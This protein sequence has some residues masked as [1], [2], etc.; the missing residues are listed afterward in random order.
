MTLH[1]VPSPFVAAGHHGDKPMP[2]NAFAEQAIL[3]AVLLDN[4]HYHEAAGRIDAADFSLDAHR[5][6]FL[7]IGELLQAGSSV[8]MITLVEQLQRNKEL[9]LIGGAAYL[10]SLTEGLPR[11]P[12]IEDYVRIVKDKSLLRQTI[13]ESDRLGVLAVDQAGS[14]EEVL[15]EAELAFRRI[16]GQAISPGLISVAGYLQRHYPS[17]DCIFDRNARLAGVASGFDDL[18]ELTSG[19]QP[20]ELIILG[21][22][23]SIG[24]NRGRRQHR[25]Q[26][27]PH[28]QDGRLLQPG[29]AQQGADRSHVLWGRESG[30]AGPPPGPPEPGAEATLPDRPGP[31][32][33]DAALYRRPARPDCGR[34]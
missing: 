18:D 16:A 30:S 32:G 21:A 5:R 25:R 29:N 1:A 2:A 22:R 26:R 9:S 31:A 11:S 27:S 12:S 24:K 33:G 34:D 4:R 8:D 7:R 3:G 19:F 6:I 13:S 10:A 15:V 23:P 17:L 14:A 20:Q 28:R